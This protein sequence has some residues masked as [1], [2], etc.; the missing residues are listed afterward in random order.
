MS[1]KV[2]QETSADRW[3]SW[4]RGVT[5]TVTPAGTRLYR[6]VTCDAECIIGLS[7]EQLALLGT[8]SSAT[9]P[10]RF[11]RPPAPGSRGAAGRS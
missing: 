6:V 3:S 1:G 11:E 10:P 5:V 2:A 8:R 7:L 9:P 4:R